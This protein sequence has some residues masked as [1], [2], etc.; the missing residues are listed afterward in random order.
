M[1]DIKFKI[2]PKQGIDPI[3]KLPLK[4]NNGKDSGISKNIFAN[5]YTKYL[6][7]KKNGKVR[8]YG[9]ITFLSPLT[10]KSKTP[11]TL[12]DLF[13]KVDNGLQIT[14]LNI[15]FGKRVSLDYLGDDKYKEKV[16]V[17]DK[18]K[19]IDG[20][21]L[22]ISNDIFG[23]SIYNFVINSDHNSSDLHYI[24]IDFIEYL[25]NTIIDGDIL[26]GDNNIIEEE[27]KNYPLTI[28]GVIYDYFYN[29]K[30]KLTYGDNQPLINDNHYSYNKKV[31]KLLPDFNNISI[32]KLYES[33]V[34]EEVSI[35]IIP[36]NINNK[37][38]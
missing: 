22:K 38:R 4:S 27:F 1:A 8:F 35:S 11:E 14:D 33:Y 19:F 7:D 5:L 24:I 28:D 10:G 29:N 12:E 13:Q 26:D 36:N 15:Y 6:E 9:T 3:F 2:R 31:F 21:K 20:F 25:P 17:Y 37:C 18:N 16:I 30:I 32:T 34:N 23:N